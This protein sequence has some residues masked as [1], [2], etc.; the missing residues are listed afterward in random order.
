MYCQLACIAICQEDHELLRALCG[1]KDQICW[2][3]LCDLVVFWHSFHLGKGWLSTQEQTW[4]AVRYNFG[5]G[6]VSAERCQCSG[7]W[8][9]NNYRD[10]ID[11]KF[12]Y[13]Q[14]CHFRNFV[15]NLE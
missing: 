1:R 3:S 5:T 11:I 9:E 6:V 10:H 8:Y 7:F 14:W 2:L 12:L 13:K 4:R 15:N